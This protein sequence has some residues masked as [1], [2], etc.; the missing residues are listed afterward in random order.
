M[1]K[2]K[3]RWKKISKFDYFAKY[4]NTKGKFNIIYD[5]IGITFFVHDAD[6]DEPLLNLDPDEFKSWIYRGIY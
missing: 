6:T 5:T 2:I 3:I 4:E 1:F